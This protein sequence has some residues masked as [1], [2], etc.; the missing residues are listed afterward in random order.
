[1]E[2]N[3]LLISK[4]SSFMID[5]LTKALKDNNINVIHTEPKISELEK[6]KDDPGVFLFYLGNFV[7]EI[8]DVLVFLKDMCIEYDKTLC[9]IGD[10]TEYSV[11]TNSIPAEYVKEHFERPLDIKKVSE[12]MQ[13]VLSVNDSL[14][15]RKKILLVDDD[16]TYLTMVKAWLDEAYRVVIVNSGMQ[17]IT[18]LANNEPDLILLDYEMPVTSGPQVLE[19]I[20][21][22]AAT[23]T[24]PV[25]F[26]TGKSDKESVMK[27]L[28][29]KP[30]G[31]LLKSMGKEELLKSISDFFE[32]NKVKTL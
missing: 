10:A 23:S 11:M 18:Y 19:M 17:A 31:Y 4:G 21:T 12:N 30:N 25:I 5:A 8:S 24:T 7:D 9:V 13:E 15:K 6:Y 14:S 28:A 20:R 22:E 1:M 2:N 3:L 29:L 32:V 16:P 26:L 27:V